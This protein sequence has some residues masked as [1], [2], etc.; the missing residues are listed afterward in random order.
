MAVMAEMTDAMNS[1]S[2]PLKTRRTRVKICGITTPA[3][4]LMVAKSG[5]DAIG[6]V[7]YEPSPRHVEIEQARLIA[8]A[9][10]AFVT[11]TALFVNPSVDDVRAVLARVAIDLIQFHGDETPAFCEQFGKPYMKA[12]RMQESTDLFAL[13]ALYSTA[14]ALLLDTYKAGVPGGTG[15]QFNWNWIPQGFPK[16]LVLAGGLNVQNVAQAIEQVQP[17]AV[18]VSG[19]VEQSKGVK[20]AQQVALFMQQVTSTVE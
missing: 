4:A 1:D 10:P 3:D 5:A 12:V 13:A 6:L 2:S 11:K 14:S 19:G 18:D 9:V 17:W 15:E 16:A 20:S 8:Q 7:F